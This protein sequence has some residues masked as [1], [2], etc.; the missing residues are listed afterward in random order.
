MRTASKH[1]VNWLYCVE[2]R[3]CYV[4]G[5]NGGIETIDEPIPWS[6]GD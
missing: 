6:Q 4:H 3:V 2:L 5:V 1:A